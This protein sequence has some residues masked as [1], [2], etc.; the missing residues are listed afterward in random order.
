MK[1]VTG[2]NCAEAWARGA[3]AVHE[4]H[5][6]LSPLVTE[7]I[8]PCFFDVAWMSDLSPRKLVPSADTLHSVIEMVGPDELAKF[9]RP[10]VYIRAWK[11]YDRCRSRGRHLSNWRD[12]YFERLTR[13]N[14]Y[15]RL[16]DIITKMRTWQARRVAP[17]YA[18]TNSNAAG[19]IVPIGS[20]CLQYV[21]F[22]QRGDN[23]ID[24]FAL[25]R[26]HDFFL[27]ALGNFIGLGRVL[28]FV[29]R[30]TNQVPGKLT[31]FSVNAYLDHQGKVCPLARQILNR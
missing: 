21:Q 28:A 26:N 13:D 15:N 1:C 24:L 7:I 22:A 2:D 3:L 11:K 25:Y 5:G 23:K 16:D 14:A 18:H 6:P 17:F 27:K 10:D 12:T 4:N 8:D 29:A 31:C 30:E 20:P 9:Q 19:G